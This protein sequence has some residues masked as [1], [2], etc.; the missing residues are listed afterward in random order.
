LLSNATAGV[1]IS[2]PQVI[3]TIIDDDTPS[4][5]TRLLSIQN[6]SVTEEDSGTID[7]VFQ[8]S[9]S[10]AAPDV[11]EVA[12][13]TEEGSATAD[14]DY[15]STSGTITFAPGDTA[16]SIAV[17]VIGDRFTED[18]ERFNVRL[19]NLVGDAQFANNLA[20][21]TI[22]TDEP[23]AR[24]SIADA[25]NLEGDAGTSE[26]NFVVSLSAASEDPVTFDYATT[27]ISPGNNAATDGT[28][29]VGVSGFG[30]I[31]AGELQL[32]IP[33]T[34]NGDVDNEYDENLTMTIDNL[35]LNATLSVGTATGTL[36]NDD[37]GPGWQGAADEGAGREPIVDLN[38]GGNGAVAWHRSSTFSGQDD[39]VVAAAVTASVLQPA[40]DIANTFNNYV[41]V[42]AIGGNDAVVVWMTPVVQSSVRDA[43]SWTTADVDDGLNLYTRIAGN[44]NDNA[45]VVWRKDPENAGSYYDIWRSSLDTAT[46]TFLPAELVEFDDTGI[47]GIPYIAMNEAGDTLIVWTQ[48]FNDFTLNGTYFDYFDGATQAWTGAA[49]IAGTEA[50]EP[51]D[52]AML[53]DGRA[54]MA[55]RQFGSPFRSTEAWLYDAAAG[56]WTSLGTVNAG[57]DQ[58]DQ[59]GLSAI[60]VDG[61]DNLFVAWQQESRG[62]GDWQIWASRYDIST[63]A[64]AAS[65][66][67]LENLGRVQPFDGFDVAADAS[68]NAIAVW[69]QVVESAG[70]TDERIRAAR[71]SLSDAV[72]APAE[73]IDDGDG[74]RDSRYP[75]IDLDA[76]GNAVAVWEYFPEGRIGSNRYVPN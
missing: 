63:G 30:E 48:T 35:S 19:S 17:P 12:Y 65:P 54:A 3:G 73:I 34:V 70:L 42:T 7:M 22:L 21:G 71:Y 25:A 62:N 4:Q 27:E 47:T 23:V 24:V 37:A 1:T 38:S 31:P 8:L 14:V 68:G 2:T 15:T 28:D 51:W 72:W 57:A 40:E 53:S 39:A 55:G 29:F 52:V 6:A 5:T 20:S 56:Q 64:W 76:G 13:A 44:E 58:P 9:L 16:A 36:I 66:T 45:T 75:R 10:E 18:N 60:T 32:T 67:R 59:M 26:L 61:S 49:R 50:F 69:V 41:D 33:V 74:G 43:G 46:G 11:V